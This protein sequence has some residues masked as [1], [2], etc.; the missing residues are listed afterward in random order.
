MSFMLP[1]FCPVLFEAYK[2][3]NIETKAS[4]TETIAEVKDILFIAVSLMDSRDIQ[5]ITEIKTIR[6]IIQR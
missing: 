3:T 6:K 2:D 5:I 4:T 1:R